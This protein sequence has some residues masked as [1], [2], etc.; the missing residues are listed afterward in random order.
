ME[1]VLRGNFLCHCFRCQTFNVELRN[2]N[3]LVLLAYFVV[4]HKSCFQTFSSV[5]NLHSIFKTNVR[6]YFLLTHQ[7]VKELFSHLLLLV[8]FANSLE[9]Y[10]ALFNVICSVTIYL[11]ALHEVGRISPP[12][13][14]L[15]RWDSGF[16][17]GLTA[18]LLLSKV[19]IRKL[20]FSLQGFKDEKDQSSFVA[21]S[22][23]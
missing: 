3:P 2:W 6:A 8:W 20:I 11:F 16:S 19:L 14:V 7:T 1:S 5:V 21:G 13:T 23:S 9:K 4:M 18:Y 22:S 15:V 12:H 10:L 17:G